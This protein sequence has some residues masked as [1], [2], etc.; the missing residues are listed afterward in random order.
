MMAS[1]PARPWRKL[2]G[3]DVLVRDRAGDDHAVR[4]NAKVRAA[5]LGDRT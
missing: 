2:W 5:Y 3:K 4:S 1:A